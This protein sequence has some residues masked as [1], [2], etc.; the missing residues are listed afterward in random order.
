MDDLTH[1]TL[2]MIVGPAAIGKSTLMH[3]VEQQDDRFGYVRSFTTRP[4]RLDGKSTYRHISTAEAEALQTSG[5][6]ITF[7]HHPTTGMIYGT[8]LESYGAEFNLLDMLS[9]S[10]ESYRRLP[11]KSTVTISLTA[12]ADDWR[13]WF[14]QR[15]PEAGDERLKR[16]REARISIEWSLSQ[17]TNH[18]WIVNRPDHL[19]GSSSELIDLVE[20][21]PRSMST[22]PEA[23]ELLQ[24][25]DELLAADSKQITVTEQSI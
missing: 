2:V 3:A 17:R 7:L 13:A 10:V 5:Q 15:Y 16:L 25:V 1:K 12:P 11:F 14:T 4:D 20:N 6:A 22:P 18:A 24:A 8:T 21:G 23:T 19:A 9:G